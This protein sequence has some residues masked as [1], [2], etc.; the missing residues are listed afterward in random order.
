M[1]VDSTIKEV[2]IASVDDRTKMNNFISNY[3]GRVTFKTDFVRFH[4]DKL[5]NILTDL[6]NYVDEL[7]I[8]P[9]INDTLNYNL[10][11]ESRDKE[12]VLEYLTQDF[13]LFL[14]RDYAKQETIEFIFDEIDPY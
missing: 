5:N 4:G 11:F 2:Y 9:E 12:Q 3:V 10:Y 1:I 8:V 7:I 14:K 13:G 6:T